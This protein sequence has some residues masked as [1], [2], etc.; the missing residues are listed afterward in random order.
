MRTMLRTVL[1]VALLMFPGMVLP[2]GAATGLEPRLQPRDRGVEALGESRW[3]VV[4]E[5]LTNPRGLEFGPD[6]ALYVAESGVGGAGNC[7]PPQ[8]DEEEEACAGSTGAITRIAAAGAQERI[9]TGLASF[10]GGGFGIGPTDVSFSADG[11]GWISVGLGGNEALRDLLGAQGADLGTVMRFDD[12]QAEVFAD[13][14]AFEEAE[15]PDDSEE[16]DSNPYGVL[17]TGDAVYVVDAGGNTLLAVDDAGA[18]TTAAVFPQQDTPEGP[19]DSVPSAAVTG[20]DG[21]V[22]VSELA[23]GA[24]PGGARIY[25]HRPGEALEVY[26]SG[27]TTAVDLAFGDDGSL[28]VLELAAEL[29]EDEDEVPVSRIVRVAPDGQDRTVTASAGLVMPLGMAMGPDGHLYVSNYGNFFGEGAGQVLRIDPDAEPVSSA[30]PVADVPRAGFTDV[31]RA[32][33]HQPA[34]DCAAW[35]NLVVGFTGTAYG[36]AGTVTRGQMATMIANAIDAV[37]ADL[38]AA[39]ADEFTDSAGVH[40]SN[41][42]R[43]GAAEIV[44]GYPDGR[45]R[46]GLPVSRAQMATFL[47]AAYEYVG[48]EIVMPDA[49]RFTDIAGDTHRG[50][51]NKVAEAGIALGYG[52]NTFRPRPDVRRDQMA[53]FLV[54]LLGALVDDGHIELEG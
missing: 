51:I 21:A 45:F 41:V 17:A 3:E 4:A 15:N 19:R 1:I 5:G 22:Y 20:P 11:T 24:G 44:R 27:F 8:D 9:L 10:G 37:G 32:N 48:D 46:S 31:T 38:P 29:P 7:L 47:A 40:E 30:G 16:P 49:D 36:P 33:V 2:T 12:G 23:E 26:A 53:T 43:L 52:D 14:L 13:I 50:S 34:I 54:K 6:G 18:V 25:R 42:N 35:W 28:Y 39:D